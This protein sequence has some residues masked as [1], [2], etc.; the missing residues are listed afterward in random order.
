MSCILFAVIVLSC[1]HCVFGKFQEDIKNENLNCSEENSSLWLW[2][3]SL[4]NLKSPTFCKEYYSEKI[5]FNQSVKVISGPLVCNYTNDVKI[6]Q[7][8][9][10][11]IVIERLEGRISIKSARNNCFKLLPAIKKISGAKM[12]KGNLNGKGSVTF[13]DET[14]LKVTFNKSIIHGQVLLF[15]KH[16]ELQVTKSKQS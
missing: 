8:K 10:N 7:K 4:Q 16:E 6:T 2:L 5:N 13:Q 14:K 1:W 11:R 12:D 3:H 15:D 9:N